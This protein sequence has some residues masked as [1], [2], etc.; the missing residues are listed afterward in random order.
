MKVD[1]LSGMILVLACGWK[2]EG[3]KITILLYDRYF[4]YKIVEYKV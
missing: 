2:G 4:I 1:Y 3:N